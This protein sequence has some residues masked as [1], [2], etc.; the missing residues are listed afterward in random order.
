MTKASWRKL[1]HWQ[2]FVNFFFVFLKSGPQF[3]N[4]TLKVPTQEIVHTSLLDME[5]N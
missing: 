5:V 4:R 1:P 2:G 3:P